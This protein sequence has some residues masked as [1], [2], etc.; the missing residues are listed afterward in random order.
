MEFMEL[1]EASAFEGYRQIARNRRPVNWDLRMARMIDL[2]ENAEGAHS[3]I[4]QGRIVEAMGTT[5]FPTLFGDV[6]DREVLKGY[7]QIPG[8]MRQLVRVKKLNDFELV[9]RSK[10][11]GFVQSLPFVELE[12]GE[13]KSR[14]KGVGHFEYRLQKYGAIVDLTW[15]AFLRDVDGFFDDIIPGLASSAQNT[16]E[17]FLTELYWDANGPLDSFFNQATGQAGVSALPLTSSN[18]GTAIKE[19]KGARATYRIK[20]EPVLNKPLWLVVGGALEITAKTILR[21]ADYGRDFRSTNSTAEAVIANE[22]IKL[23]VN[24]WIDVVVTAGS[25]GATTWALFSENIESGELGVLKGHEGPEL[26]M[27]HPDA[28]RVGGG[29]INAFDGSF[30]NDGIGYK[31][32]LAQGGVVLD[33]LG[34]WASDG[35]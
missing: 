32:R 13:Y 28:T 10:D 33:P 20:S 35:Q 27:R 12:G 4:H 25:K 3:K 22:G 31:V 18:L 14:K 1:Q 29:D 19:M 9:R 26:F 11:T 16:E 15:E 30:L 2:L 7:E 34:A 8:V 17:R 24:P 5:D 21:A 23:I 6:L